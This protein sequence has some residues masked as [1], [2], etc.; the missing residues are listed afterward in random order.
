MHRM[1]HGLHDQALFLGREGRGPM[2]GFYVAYALAFP[3]AE[4][5]NDA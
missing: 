5:D 1:N 2:T 4:D 3:P